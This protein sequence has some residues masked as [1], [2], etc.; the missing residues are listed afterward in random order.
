MPRAI[1]AWLA[2]LAA[3]A[4]TA[5]SETPKPRAATE[6][7]V[8]SLEKKISGFSAGFVVLNRMV[9][10]RWLGLPCQLSLVVTRNSFFRIIFL[11]MASLHAFTN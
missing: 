2:I 10:G 6:E 7:P 5:K 1:F 11:G 4:C 8:E 9:L 3:G